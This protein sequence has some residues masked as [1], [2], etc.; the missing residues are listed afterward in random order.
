M[1][2]LDQPNQFSYESIAYSIPINGW[3]TRLLFNGAHSE[4][5][6]GGALSVL[7]ITSRA[8]TYEASVVHP[9]IKSTYET[10]VAEVGF[11]SKDNPL[12]A[13]GQTLFSDHL[14]MAKAGVSYDRTDSWGRNFASLYGF[15]GLGHILGGMADNSLEA[16]HVGADDRFR[17][18]NLSLGRIHALGNDFFFLARGMG[19]SRRAHYRLSSRCY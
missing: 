15:Q 13:L 16:S 7:N 11:A 12:F 3:G 1:E 9:F 2:L 8:Y 18:A 17:K 4:F 19:Q 5:G 6:I 10:L 14:R